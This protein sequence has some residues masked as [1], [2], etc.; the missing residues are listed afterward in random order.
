MLS[1]S[2]LAAIFLTCAVGTAHASPPQIVRV[3]DIPYGANDTHIFLLRSL[4]DNMGSHG[5]TQTDILLVARNRSTNVDDEIWPVARSLEN[6]AFEDAPPEGRVQA[7]ALDGAVNPFDVLA[8][9]GAELMVGRSQDARFFSNISITA[10]G[11][12]LVVV[13]ART[14]ER[15]QM[16][17]AEVG[18]LLTDNLN[19]SRAALPAYFAEM[20]IDV[21]QDAPFTPQVDCAFSASFGLVD[22]QKQTARLVAVTCKGEE[23]YSP[24]TTY[25]VMPPAG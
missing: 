19:R 1:Q 25:L 23:V 10:E 9:R 6:G 13:D 2:T 20:N 11:D 7:I 4:D 16:G 12:Q 14:E 18:Q 3:T 24:I 17:Y 15:Y 8:E 22:K 21:L 5:R